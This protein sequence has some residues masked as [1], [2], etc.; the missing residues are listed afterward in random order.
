LV[1]DGKSD[2][3]SD[4]DPICMQIGQRI[5]F[6]N[7][8]VRAPKKEEEASGTVFPLLLFALLLRPGRVGTKLERE[9]ETTT[10]IIIIRRRGRLSQ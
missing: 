3:E 5:G 4:G 6:K 2:K 10:E 7:V 1:S 8:R 9:R